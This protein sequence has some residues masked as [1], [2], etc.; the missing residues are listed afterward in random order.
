MRNTAARITHICLCPAAI[1][2]R[3]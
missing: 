3:S 1:D 2:G